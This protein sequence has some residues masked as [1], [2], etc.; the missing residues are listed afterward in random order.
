MEKLIILKP[1]LGRVFACKDPRDFSPQSKPVQQLIISWKLPRIFAYGKDRRHGYHRN[2]PT[3]SLAHELGGVNKN[4][5]LYL[6]QKSK[7][8]R[9]RPVPGKGK[10][11]R[12]LTKQLS[13]R[14]SKL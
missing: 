10:K 8:I 13:K 4:Q 6:S 2:S 11:H 5:Q 14:N 1:G 3:N 7:F 12:N 9:I